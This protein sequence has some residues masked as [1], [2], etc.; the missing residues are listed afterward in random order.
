MAKPPYTSKDAKPPDIGPA[1]RLTA[2]GR[3]EAEDDRLSLL[4]CILDPLSRRRRHMVR[5]GWRCLEV[6]AGRGSMAVWLAEKVGE[7]GKVVAT[8]ID[9][10]Y[11]K[12]IYL[13]N[14]EVRQHDILNDS[15]DALGPGSF[16]MVCS[17]LT[18][19]WL[20]DKQESAIRRMVECLRPGGWL[21]DEDGDWGTIAPVDPSHPY[22]AG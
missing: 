14:L 16:D 17:R 5:P 10:T 13:P 21:V 20:A 9:V 22:Y 4:E 8:D 3:Q 11:L 7:S 6:G 19:F 15:V 1:Y 12:R 2:R 18:L